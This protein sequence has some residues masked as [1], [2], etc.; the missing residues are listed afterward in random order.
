MT[1]RSR[2]RE[3]L[4]NNLRALRYERTVYTAISLATIAGAVGAIAADVPPESVGA[5]AGLALGLLALRWVM[6]RD[7]EK[8]EDELAKLQ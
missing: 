1:R 7:V 6:N 3:A 2:D 5:V 8:R 4:R